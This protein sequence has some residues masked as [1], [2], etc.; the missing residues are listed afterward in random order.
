M[1]KYTAVAA[2]FVLGILGAWL[3]AGA[4]DNE[5]EAPASVTTFD[6]FLN[7]Y[8]AVPTLSL[9]RSVA[10]A[11]FHVRNNQM[12]DYAIEFRLNT[13]DTGTATQIHLHF[14]RRA[15]EGGVIA[16]LCSNLGNAPAGTP[17]CPSVSGTVTGTWT[18]ASIVGPAVQ[19][20]APG[21]FQEVVKAIRAR[22]TYAC[23][24]TT[25]FVDGSIRGQLQ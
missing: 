15:T 9:P 20:I 8:Q 17:P 6:A 19:G 12:I 22:A 25:V 16:F 1:L 7:G 13:A 5:P 3:V 4:H 23:I 14:G 10:S 2:V 21:E 11:I 24:H 18:P